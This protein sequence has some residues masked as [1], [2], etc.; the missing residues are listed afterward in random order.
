[1][2]SPLEMILNM[3][4]AQHNIER[5][6]TIKTGIRKYATHRNELGPVGAEGHTAFFLEGHRRGHVVFAQQLH[7]VHCV[8]AHL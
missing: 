3:A 1:M 5:K 7:A 4:Q 8:A 2:Q 6:R